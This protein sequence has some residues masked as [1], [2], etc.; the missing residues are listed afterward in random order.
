MPKVGELILLAAPSCCGK[1][2]FLEELFAGRLDDVVAAMNI[3]APMNSYVPVIA[4]NI[5]DIDCS[6][7]PRMILH[8]AIP[9]IA[10]NDGSLRNIADDPRLEILKDSERV[11]VVTLLT[12][13]SI[14]ASRLRSRYIAN[15]KMILRDISKF[16]R[17]HR[18]MARLKQ[19]YADPDKVMVAY[20]AWFA[21]SNTLPNLANEWIITADS[22]YEVFSGREW[23]SM[24]NSYFPESRNASQRA[25]RKA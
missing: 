14:L 17:G 15:Y 1:T 13:A 23:Q 5:S 16:R 19:M 4:M 22:T 3:R 25:S 18:R 8:F 11:T 10:L 24:R 12:S 7:V 6:T 20:D 21:Y 9:T 2:R